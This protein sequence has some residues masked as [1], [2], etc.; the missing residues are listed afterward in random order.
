MGLFS[1]SPAYQKTAVSTSSVQV[2]D[3]TPSVNGSDFTL[4]DPRDIT[5]VNTGPST[6]YVGQTGVTASTGIPVAAGDQLTLQGPAVALY[7]I[8]ASGGSAT[9]EAT[10]ATVASVV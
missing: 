9:V 7:A 5:L 3:L 1:S 10:L 6:V 2:F 4:V 8:C